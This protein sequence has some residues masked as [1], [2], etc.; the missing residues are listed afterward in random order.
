MTVMKLL[1]GS[2]SGGTE[3]FLHGFLNVLEIVIDD[4]AN[5]CV[6]ECAVDAKGL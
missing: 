1:Y 3:I 5:F 2:R 6:L 4:A